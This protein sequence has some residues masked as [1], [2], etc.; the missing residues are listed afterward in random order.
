MPVPNQE[1]LNERSRNLGAFNG[2]RLVL[3]RLNPAGNP[4]EARLTVHFFNNNEI[5]NIL[6][7]TGTPAGARVT[8]PITGGRRG[9]AG[10]LPGAGAAGGVSAT[11]PA[12]FMEGIV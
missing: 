9:P 10:P 2:I 4:T 7:A 1:A 11:S 8:F 3:V 6:A 12:Q 5:S